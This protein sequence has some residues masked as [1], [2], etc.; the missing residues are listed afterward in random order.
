MAL[1]ADTPR[2]YEVGDV[3][4][5]PVKAATKIYEGAAVGDD[6]AG[7]ARGLVASDPFRGFAERQADNSAGAAGAKNVRVKTKGKVQLAVTNLAITDVG[8]DV[9]ASDDGTFVLTQSTNTRI[10]TVYRYVSSGVG[11]VEFNA[12][13]GV[14]T[15]L[16]DSSGGTAGDTLAAI[17]ETYTQATLR[18]AIASLAAKV[19]ALIRRLG[20]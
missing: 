11:I 14:L 3:N 15:E 10:G 4:E 12:A 13:E 8:K 20:N 19:N 1:A 6:A 7:Y 17:E 2:A 18:N 9:F 16:T 5:L